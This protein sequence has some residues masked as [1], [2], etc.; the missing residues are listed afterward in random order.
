MI[1]RPPRSTRTDT[2]FPYT[3]LF[4]SDLPLMESGEPLESILPAMTSANAYLG[5]DLICRALETKAAVVITGRVG[6]PSLFLAP[7]LHHF[8]WSYD[9]TD[10]LAVGSL[11]DTLLEYWTQATC[12]GFADPGRKHVAGLHEPRHPHNN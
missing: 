1:R 8:G 4:R 7:A 6:D 2:L 9:D 12:G 11:A 5:A 10:H 3:T